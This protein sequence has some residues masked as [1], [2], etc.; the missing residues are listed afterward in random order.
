MSWR[1]VVIPMAFPI[2]SSRPKPRLA[3]RNPL[4]NEEP[5][6]E[7]F[8]IM[9]V[10]GSGT[11]KMT[12]TTIAPTDAARPDQ[13]KA[14]SLSARPIMSAARDPAK[15]IYRLNSRPRG[16]MYPA[17]TPVISAEKIPIPGLK[18]TANKMGRVAAG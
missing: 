17:R 5:N 11:R 14:P 13:I 16:A 3:E 9:S 6:S 18:K 2:P 4:I 7:N 10:A 15:I 12:T 8:P 1:L